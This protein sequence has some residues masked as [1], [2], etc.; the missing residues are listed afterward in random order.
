MVIKGLE[1]QFDLNKGES[2]GL[3]TQ[4]KCSIIQTLISCF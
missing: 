2:Y 3:M 1:N 4:P